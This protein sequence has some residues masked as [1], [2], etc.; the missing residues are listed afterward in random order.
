MQFSTGVRRP[1]RPMPMGLGKVK[2]SGSPAYSGSELRLTRLPNAPGASER[3][4]ALVMVSS[5]D[6]QLRRSSRV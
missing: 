5:P 3:Y 6:R 2:L 1:A 4:R